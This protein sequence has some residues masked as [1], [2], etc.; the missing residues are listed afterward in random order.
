MKK[1]HLMALL[2]LFV[3]LFAFTACGDD[4]DDDGGNDSPIV[5]T[6]VNNE[7]HSG[8]NRTMERSETYQ[9]KANNTF[10]HTEQGQEGD[11]EATYSWGY[12]EAGTYT[13]V[14]EVVVMAVT[15]REML[16]PDGRWIE[17]PMQ[18]G[19]EIIN[20]YKAVIS[21]KKLSMAWMNEDGT[22]SD[23]ATEFTKK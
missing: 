22:V 4:D 14:N 12:R 5:G 16:E 20:R 7:S 15:N 21:G 2:G 11:A 17:E 8:D 10:V 6:W 19:M 3:S 1:L 23:Y 13:Y 18:E 9:F